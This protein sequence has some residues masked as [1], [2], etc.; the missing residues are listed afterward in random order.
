MKNICIIIL[1]SIFIISCEKDFFEPITN[2]NRTQIS[3]VSSSSEPCSLNCSQWEKCARKS[4][5]GDPFDFFGPRR[6]TCENIFL[7]YYRTGR[8]KSRQTIVDPNGLSSTKDLYVRVS[9]PN[10]N[11]VNLTLGD[12]DSYEIQISFIDSESGLFNVSN[13]SVYHSQINDVI[14]YNGNGS[15]VKNGSSASYILE[16]D[17]TFQYSGVDY[18]FH[19]IGSNQYGYHP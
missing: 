8:F 14:I 4:I 5:S 15:F 18:D 12:L 13:H 10:E 17:L 6:W 16:L 3:N 9:Y 11:R 1:I 7:K 19:L 2:E